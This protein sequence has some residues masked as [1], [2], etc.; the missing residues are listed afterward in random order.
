MAKSSS[1]WRNPWV[2]GMFGF[3]IVF[4]VANVH[5]IY[6]SSTGG[7]GLVV[8]NYYERGE[9]YEKTMLKRQAQ[10]P[11]WKMKLITPEPLKVGKKQ[12]INIA[13]MDK[14]VK[15]INRDSVVL[16]LYR[17]SD[18][19]EDFSLP[20]QRIDEGLY[21]VEISF[22]LPGVW[23]VLVSMPNKDHEVNLA[24]RIDVEK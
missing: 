2:L 6:L 14:A 5:M 18:K 20:M 8:D 17:P 24:Y 13:V 11:G 1:P 9:H 15:P 21:E 10:D 23:D 22:S 4:V 7:P 16:N 12:I 3:L 19:N